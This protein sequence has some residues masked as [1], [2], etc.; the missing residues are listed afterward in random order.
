L[1]DRPDEDREL[2]ASGNAGVLVSSPATSRMKTATAKIG[3]ECTVDNGEQRVNCK[4]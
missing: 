2:N 4:W 3:F 1:L